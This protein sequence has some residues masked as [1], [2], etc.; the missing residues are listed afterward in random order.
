V[1]CNA[2]VL[3]RGSALGTAP[4]PEYLIFHGDAGSLSMSSSHGTDDRIQRFMPGQQSWEEVPISQEGVA[5]LPQTPDLFQRCWSQFFRE[6][7][8]DVNGGTYSSYP[9]FRD[10]YTA[11]AIMDIART[12][13]DWR[14]LQSTS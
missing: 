8:A 6:F 7:A 11:V 4:Q 5:T 2:N 1:F 12:G 13:Y 10:G 14:I 3:F 9:T